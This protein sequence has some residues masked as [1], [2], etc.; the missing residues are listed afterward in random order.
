MKTQSDLLEELRNIVGNEHVITTTENLQRYVTSTMAEQNSPSALLSPGSEQEVVDIVKVFNKYNSSGL[1]NSV[2]LHPIS[3]G[4][5]WG[6]TCAEPGTNNAYLLNLARLNTISNYEHTLGTVRI[7]AGVTQQQ[8]YSFLV[9]NGLKHWMDATG[10]SVECSILGNALERGFGHTP[11]GNHFEFISDLDVVF[12]SGEKSSTGFRQ[13]SSESKAFFSEGVYKWGVGPYVDGL[14]SQSSMGIVT[15]ATLSLMPAPEAYL[16][17][18]ITTSD[19]NKLS[20]LIEKLRRLREKWIVRSCIHITNLDKSLQAALEVSDWSLSVEPMSSLTKDAFTNSY[21]LNEWTASGALY[22]SKLEIGVW[23]KIIKQTFNSK[24]FKVQF[25]GER[26]LPLLKKIAPTVAK[27]SGKKI[28]KTLEKLDSLMKLKR[29][30]PTN[31][32]LQSVHYKL[33][34]LPKDNDYT[35]LE[36]N[37]VGLIWLAPIAPATGEH[38]TTISR[39][40]ASV[41]K[42]YNV[43]SAISMTLLT[44][45]TVDC[46]ISLLYDRR[47]S[48]ADESAEK[49]HNAL[50][51][52]LTNAGY[53]FYRLNSFQHRDFHKRYSSTLTKPL[54]RLKMHLDPNG[55]LTGG[56]YGL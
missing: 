17:F 48:G 26:Q 53:L 28:D 11:Y 12:G 54:K 3:S 50:V 32:F 43:E 34:E 40:V 8:L 6:Y 23:K 35:Q 24:D 20:E 2:Q 37:K 36:R 39:I 45:Q 29:G 22:G 25:I 46:V 15:S 55:V 21:M 27:L 9:D 1:G 13:F 7:Q 47:I 30:E 51:D 52:S 18:F 5:N 42:E 49:C 19:K 41:L 44:P 14:F 4:K 16:P 31:D 38:A 10:S 56:R 33:T